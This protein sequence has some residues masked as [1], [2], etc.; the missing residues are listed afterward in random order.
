MTTLHTERL[1]LR[2]P[3]SD[4]IAPLL[5]FFQ[6]DRSHFYGGPLDAPAA[7][8][9]FAAFVGD[10]PLRGY[11]MYAVIRRDTGATIGMAGRGVLTHLFGP[12]GWTSAVSY[13]D[14]ENTASL[15]VATRLGATLDA[16]AAKPDAL[17][18]CLAYRHHPNEA[19]A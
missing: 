4:D 13:I 17:A 11:G 9:R 14:P 2:I 12:L 6:V 16:A 19:A 3:N 5:A 1:T 7:W 15:G 8:A 10:W 18:H